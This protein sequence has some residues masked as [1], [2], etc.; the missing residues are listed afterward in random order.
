MRRTVIVALAVLTSLLGYLT[1]DVFDL[2]PGVLTRDR[3]LPRPS[4][5]AG[6]GSTVPVPA[7]DPAVLPLPVAGVGAK[8]PTAAGLRSVVGT[9]LRD[10]RLG[11]SLGVTVRDG[12]TGTHLLDLRPDRPSAPASVAKLL[13][14]AAVL[15]ELGPDARLATQAVLAGRTVF[16]LAGGDTLLAPGRGSVTAVAG[17]AGVAD[18][19]A[20]T[21][22]ALTARG[23]RSV[24][25]RLDDGRVPGPRYAPGW[26]AVDVRFGLTGPVTS[27]GMTSQR[28]LPG[29]PAPADPAALTAVAF[30]A[31][32]R[33]TGIAV[34]AGAP[35]RSRAPAAGASVLAA[36]DS[37]PVADQMALAL[38]ESD[39]ALT[40][41]LARQAAARAAV[42]TT[43]FTAVGAW[44]RTRV[45]RLGV[46]VAGVRLVDSSGL[47]GG[48]TVPARVVGDLLGLAVS[49][50]SPA[51]QSMV[52]RLP[53]AGL[54]GTLADRFRQ[55]RSH[56][57]AGVARAKTGTLTG[58]TALAGTVV[59][60]DG[61]LLTFVVLADRVP[62]A[63]GTPGARDA[64]DVL[65]SR[66]AGCGC[67]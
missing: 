24:R 42:P 34:D 67:R 54:T 33:A 44:V 58:A 59:D 56:A 25:V 46:N 17:R 19:A 52:A 47:S 31:A 48:T 16:L 40:E 49:G 29:R 51:L 63:T 12:A 11:P 7:V 66:L 21:A 39:N 62:A 26:L 4:P 36:V 15:D 61:R 32:L 53:V 28:A 6:D 18:L 64:L 43:A 2:V 20:A 23:V 37:A 9:L 3:A 35:A 13:T 38:A 41:S 65:V 8:P 50:G 27:L 45:A 14:A 10:P 1:L 5:V 30:A 55:G 57:V 22:A 60:R